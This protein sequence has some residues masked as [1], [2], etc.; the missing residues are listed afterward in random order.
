M[1]YRPN[2]RRAINRAS[3]NDVGMWLID[4]LAPWSCAFCGT[5]SVRVETGICAGCYADLPWS[6]PAVSSSPGIFEC[7]IAMLRYKFPVDAAIKAMKFKRKLFYAPAFAEILCASGPLLPDDIDAVLPVPL[8][9]W[10]QTRRGFNQAAELAKPVASML[11]VPILRGVYRKYAT[12]FQTGFGA[13]ERAK[14]LRRAF[15]VRK[16]LDNIHVL[17]IDDVITTG[18]TSGQLAKILLAHGVS[19]VSM[20]AV[21]RAD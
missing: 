10:R 16:P 14:N 4:F 19:K 2:L 6:E 11:S 5:P 1:K 18:A 20:L 13:A 17:I 8:H 7:S 12:P 15:S 21:A 9:W 3:C